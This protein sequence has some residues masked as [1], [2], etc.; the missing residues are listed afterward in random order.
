MV[1]YFEWEF[2]LLDRIYELHTPVLDGFMKF[3]SFLGNKGWFWI[4]LT[5]LFIAMPKYRRTGFKMAVSL[6]LM[7]VIG[8]MIIKP[9]VGRVRPYEVNTA[10]ELIVAKLSSYSFPSGHTFGSFAAAVVL[11]I[12]HKKIG[13]PALV[14]AVLIGFSRMYL[15]VHFPT[16]VLAGAVFGV[17][18]AVIAEITVNCISKRK[19]E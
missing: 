19:K 7:T 10:V 11:F 14:L 2:K 12:N 4:L 5:L 6:V 9:L 17:I 3:V 13:I 16:D 15:Y 1:W 18:T 8:N